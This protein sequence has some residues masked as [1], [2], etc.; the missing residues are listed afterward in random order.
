LDVF[1]TVL[2]TFDVDGRI[3]VVVGVVASEL[4]STKTLEDDVAC[5]Y[6]DEHDVEL[7]KKI[8]EFTLSD[9]DLKYS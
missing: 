7:L 5:R 4:P 1:E 2:S 9:S 3:V 6:E 8:K